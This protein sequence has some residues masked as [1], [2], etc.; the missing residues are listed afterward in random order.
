MSGDI[1]H[2]QSGYRESINKECC[3]TQPP[4]QESGHLVETQH[5]KV[6]LISVECRVH[7]KP[8]PH[9]R[10]NCWPQGNQLH[11]YLTMATHM[12]SID[13]AKTNIPLQ[14]ENWSCTDR[15]G[16]DLRKSQLNIRLKFLIIS[17]PLLATD[18][19]TIQ[20]KASRIKLS[21]QLR[22]LLFT[23]PRH[24][25]SKGSPLTGKN[26]KQSNG[27]RRTISNFQC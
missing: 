17:H 13:N 9:C 18:L 27:T 15:P 10:T 26:L 6:V 3:Y 1:Q 21:Q 7:R 22:H 20:R 16:Q 11:V 14:K 19:A 23:S 24:S 25:K 2:S 5:M 8:P 4:R 12:T